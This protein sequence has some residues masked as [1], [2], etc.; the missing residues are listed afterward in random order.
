MV[1]DTS[2]G[3]IVKSLN[4]VNDLFTDVV[5]KIVVAVV[6]LLIGFIIGKIVGRLLQRVLHEFELDNIMKMATGLKISLEELIS[7]FITYIIY[8]L[9]VV[10]ALNQ[11]G[12]TTTLLNIISAGIMILIIIFI[13]LGIKDFFPNVIAG[14]FIHQKGWI[15]VGDKIKVKNIEG[16]VVH[17]NLVDVRLETKKGDLIYIPNSLIIKNE[18]IKKR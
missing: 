1:N 9:T 11:I 3:L 10:M 14:I 6:I 18:L 7:H 17:V 15:K 5:T 12:L 16:K 2:G 8:F 4:M 13:L